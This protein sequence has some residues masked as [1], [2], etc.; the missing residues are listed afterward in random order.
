MPGRRSRRPGA[1][2]AHRPGD[3]LHCLVLSRGPAEWVAVDVATGA[4]VRVHSRAAVGPS[5]SEPSRGAHAAGRWTEATDAT[6]GATAPSPTAEALEAATGPE[7]PEHPGA[8]LA[9]DDGE[10]PARE[11]E[12]VEIELAEDLEPPDPA[13]PEAVALARPPLLLGV[14]RR[15]PVRRLLRE[16]LPR[17][18]R[19][20]L[21]GSLGPS[22][23]YGDLD[24]TR[25][26]V[27]VVSPDRIPMF[28]TDSR[29]SWCQ[30]TLGGRK[31]RL[32]VLDER[33]I[34]ATSGRRGE[35][36][37][38]DSVSAA[39]G[40]TPRYLVVGLGTPRLGQAPILVFSVLPKT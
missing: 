40:G 2:R 12:L 25:P 18:S 38:S 36:L 10:R 16:L 26:S 7:S 28:A 4:L 34:A 22:I 3:V 17:D 30:F 33:V 32:T 35:L 29:G 24:G 13:R 8:P 20:P 19:R 6:E 11:L 23:A 37:G 15:R 27:A 31:L 39:I 9:A 14:P 1:V 21:L 5:R